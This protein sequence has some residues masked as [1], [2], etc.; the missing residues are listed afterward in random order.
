[1]SN[2]VGLYELYFAVDSGGDENTLDQ[3]RRTVQNQLK[4]L[5]GVDRIAQISKGS[6]LRAPGPTLWSKL[7]PWLSH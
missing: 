5:D 7:E 3:Y 4:E 1:M 6:L 2:D